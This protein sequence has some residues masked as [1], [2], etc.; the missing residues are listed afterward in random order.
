[1][2]SRRC[3]YAAH[4]GRTRKQQPSALHER[5]GFIRQI[6]LPISVFICRTRWFRAYLRWEKNESHA[7]Q[8]LN[9]YII[10]WIDNITVMRFTSLSSVISSKWYSFLDVLTA[11]SQSSECFD[12]WLGYQ[13]ISTYSYQNYNFSLD[14]KRDILFSKWNVTFPR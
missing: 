7:L 3:G 2:H 11:I 9:S 10:R 5:A 13:D 1:M 8:Y 4:R 6:S 12:S 14:S